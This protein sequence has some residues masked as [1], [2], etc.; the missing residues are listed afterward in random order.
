[1]W[2]DS[3][4]S[5]MNLVEVERVELTSIVDNYVDIL[6]PSNEIAKR[7]KLVRD[8]Y[9]KP[10]L[11]AEHGFSTEIGVDV[12]GKMRTVLYDT[13]LESKTAVH[14]AE[15]LG[16]DLS[17][18]EMLVLSH[19]HIDHTAGLSTVKKKL[20]RRKVTAVLH[21]HAFRKRKMIQDGTSWDIPPPNRKV[22]EQCG[23]EI[24]ERKEPTEILDGR[25]LITGEIERTT[26]FEKGLPVHYAEIDGKLEKD[27]LI[28]DD[29]AL[30]MNLKNKGLVIVTGCGHA[31]LIN[32]VR[33]AQK[34]TGVREVYALFGGMHLTGGLFEPIIPRTIDELRRIDPKIAVPCHC[35]GWKAEHEISRSLPNAFIQNS[36]GTKYFLNA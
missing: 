33:Y 31:G 8:W 13:A 14:N 24:M 19:G 12:K 22:M 25:L 35:T 17:L 6:L 3:G 10:Q 32:T 28:L 4:F 7:P 29:Q 21:P 27:P 5:T 18:S 1:M 15:A 26:D 16:V 30:V 23:Y 2:P 36:V 34:I 20:G 11:I 9:A